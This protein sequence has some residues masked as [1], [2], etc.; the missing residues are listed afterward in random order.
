MSDDA[1]SAIFGLPEFDAPL[2]S[3]LP[4][5]WLCVLAGR[6]A[7]GTPLLAKQFAHA[8]VGTVPDLYYTTYE[9]NEDV[10]RAFH[11]FGWDPAGVQIIN[12]ADEYYEKVLVRDLEV[13]RA[14]ERGLQFA[15]LTPV[16]LASPAPKTFNLTN[17]LLSDLSGLKGR[18]RL[19]LDSLDF[20]LE[21]LEP[22]EVLTVARQIRHSAQSLGGQALVV[23]QSEVH[24]RRTVGLLEDMADLVVEYSTEGEDDATRHLLNVRKVRNHPERARRV[25]VT[26]T[27][28]G[29]AVGAGGSR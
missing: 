24:E 6:T 20:L 9:R 10:V 22:N 14:R 28:A 13:S 4:A 12:L 11:D 26:V 8:G 23:L 3:R 18:F 1:P 27:D 25:P 7:S 2:A 15:D 17:R 29:F 21:I 5:G 16:R 19:V